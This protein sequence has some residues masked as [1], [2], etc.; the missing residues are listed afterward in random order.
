M[1]E[2]KGTQTRKQVVIA[3]DAHAKLIKYA[4][5]KKIP[6]SVIVET[7]IDQG[8]EHDIYEPNAT[9]SQ[10]K[11]HVNR[12]QYDWITSDEIGKWYSKLQRLL[13]RAQGEQI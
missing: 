8:I 6:M 13:S 3:E 7:L 9:V 12:F 1:K 2:R 11:D 10:I 5:S 4:Q